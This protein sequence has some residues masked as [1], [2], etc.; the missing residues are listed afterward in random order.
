MSAVEELFAHLPAD[1]RRKTTL[2]LPPSKTEAEL[3]HYFRELGRK[4][5]AVSSNGWLSFLGAGCYEHFIPAVV[6]NL[7]SRGEFA[8]AYT[9]Y[10]PEVSQG[11]LQAI[12]EFQSMIANLFSLDVANASMYDGA[13]SIAEAV[14]MALRIKKGSRVYISKG[15]HPDYR[16]TIRTYVRD[17]DV[18][19]SDLDVDAEGKTLTTRLRP[20]KA[21]VVVQQPNFFGVV[22]PIETMA[23]WVHKSGALFAVTTTEAMAFGLLRGPGSQGADVVA[24]EGQSFGNAMSYGGPHVGLFA[25]KK[26]FIRQLPGRLVGKTV[27]QEGKDGYVLTLATREQHIRRERATSNI[28]TNHSLCA[29]RSCI[30]MALVGEKGLREISLRNAW[31]ARKLRARLLEIQGVQP[32]YTGP[33]FNEFALRLPISSDAY[34]ASM[35]QQKILGGVPLSRWDKQQDREIL[36]ALTETKSEDDVERYVSAARNSL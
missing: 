23:E 14:L 24:G 2:N 7:V 31:V 13:S 12:F 1:V 20:D 26:E 5:E 10:Q 33:V 34:L 8:T 32:L 3:R 18:E 30:Y 19:I 21:V 15:V 4:N 27:D 29:L 17:M 36:V 9:P 28:C 6:D 16:E 22:E 25:T 11:T 35:E